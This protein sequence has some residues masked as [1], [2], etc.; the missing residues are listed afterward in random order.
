[1][2]Y[3][4]VHESDVPVT[5]M[6][7]TDVPVDL[8]MQAVDEA[9]D[10]E[11]VRV[12]LWHFEPGDAIGY[13]AQPEQEEVYYVLEGE[14]SLKLG[15]SGETEIVEVGPGAFWRAAAMVGHGHR[16]IGDEDGVV[17]AIGAPAVDE[18]GLDPHAIE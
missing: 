3:E 5:D 9:L 13:H 14:F 12:K 11:K 1:M 10:A 17:L 6:A 2:A 8:E 15:R 18:E 7:E 4:V 16:C